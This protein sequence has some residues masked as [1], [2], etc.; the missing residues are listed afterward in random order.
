M[1]ASSLEIGSGGKASVWGAKQ[2]YTRRMPLT[3]ADYLY[4]IASS[5]R[6]IGHNCRDAGRRAGN[7][8]LVAGL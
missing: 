4:S 7:H 5:L 8:G 2:I 3:I 1:A 6:P